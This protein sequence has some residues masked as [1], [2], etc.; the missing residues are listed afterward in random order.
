MS[1]P[2][3]AVENL[4]LRHG[5][6]PVLTDISLRVEPGEVVALL[7]ANGAG[8]STLLRAIMGFH[9]PASGSVTFAGVKITDVI[10]AARAR[11][12]IG[13]CP[14][15]RRVFAGM[16]VRDNLDVASHAG[17]AETRRRRDGVY[18]L[19][20]D[21]AAIEDTPSWQLSGGQQQMVAIGRA[22]MT[23]PKLLLLDE[24]SLGLSPMLAADVLKR[25]RTIAAE[26]TSVLLAE[27]NIVTALDIA[28]RA[29]L[30]DL[31]RVAD[32]G[33]SA[34]L[35]ARDSLRATL[36]GGPTPP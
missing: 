17:R 14:E 11:L 3:L 4:T 36:L 16:S 33:L 8:K 27:Q 32:E 15:G 20:P 23:G 29:Y 28:D 31:G 22:L 30:L 1:A 25:V 21:L 34:R 26:G 12:G 9:H 6:M 5:K 18:R 35:R 10:V 2:L 7:G 19:F 13:Y 24:P